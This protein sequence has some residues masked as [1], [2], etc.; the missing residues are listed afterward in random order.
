MTIKTTTYQDLVSKSLNSPIT[1][2]FKSLNLFGKDVKRTCMNS[3]SKLMWA[4]K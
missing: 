4:D 3:L 2:P 1:A